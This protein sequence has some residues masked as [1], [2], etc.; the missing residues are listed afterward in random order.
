MGQGL[1]IL[2]SDVLSL[3]GEVQVSVYNP[4]AHVLLHL[5]VLK[6]KGKCDTACSNLRNICILLTFGIILKI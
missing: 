6:S 4:I 1:S 2:V 5:Q 3:M